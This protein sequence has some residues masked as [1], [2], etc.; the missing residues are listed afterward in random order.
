MYQVLDLEYSNCLCALWLLGF[1]LFSSALYFCWLPLLN[2]L[3]WLFSLSSKDFFFFISRVIS[4]NSK[5]LGDMT[6]EQQ[7]SPLKII[8]S[9][10]NMEWRPLETQVVQLG[11]YQKM[12]LSWLMKR[13]LSLLKRITWMI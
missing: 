4:Y 10:L 6:A 2:V 9:K 1:V 11:Y 12:G 5:C 3:H 13:R 7:Y 8:S